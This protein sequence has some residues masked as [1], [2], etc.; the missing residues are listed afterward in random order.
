MMRYV[1]FSLCSWTMNLALQSSFGVQGCFIDRENSAWS[2]FEFG[3]MLCFTNAKAL[4][5]RSSIISSLIAWL[6]AGDVYPVLDLSTT[7]EGY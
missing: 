1:S 6:L 5:C 3:D 7:S 4:R 2:M